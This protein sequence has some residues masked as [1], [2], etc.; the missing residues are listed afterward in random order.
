MISKNTTEID[1]TAFDGCDNLESFS[2]EEGNPQY[3]SK[4]GVLF[5]DKCLIFFP[6]KKAGTYVIPD[7]ITEIQFGAFGACL[8]LTNVKIPSSVVKIG[9]SAFAC[10]GLVRMVIP[11][12]I[13]EIEPGTFFDCENLK[14]V[15]VPKSVVKI[16]ESAFERCIN[17]TDLVIENDDVEIGSFAFEECGYIK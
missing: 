12:S 2:V 7:N 15:I 3:W 14:S 17:L 1:R 9:E 13:K 16:G 8:N 6:Y 4:D 11:D 10:S 5:Q